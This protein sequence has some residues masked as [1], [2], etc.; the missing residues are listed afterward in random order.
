VDQTEPENQVI[1]WNKLECRAIPDMG[2]H[3]L[4]SVIIVHHISDKIQLLVTGFDKN[5]RFSDHGA[6]FAY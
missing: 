4:L 1:P 2:G 6:T 5:D 3:V